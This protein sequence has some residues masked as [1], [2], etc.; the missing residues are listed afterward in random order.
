MAGPRLRRGKLF[1]G[2][3]QRGI[4]VRYQG[5]VIGESF[6]DLL[7]ENAILIESKTVRAV[8]RTRRAQCINHLRATGIDLCLMINFGAPRVKIQ[9]VI[10][11]L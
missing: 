5:G 6:A 2:H 10:Q 11:D 4:T 3:E 1:G 7:V 9:C 8:G